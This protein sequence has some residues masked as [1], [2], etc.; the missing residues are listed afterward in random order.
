MSSNVKISKAASAKGAKNGESKRS[1]VAAA[2]SRKIVSSKPI[3]SGSPY[4]GDGMVRIRH[5]E[6]IGEIPGSVAFANVQYNVNPGL[7]ATFPW[8]SVVA[9][10]FESY[11][12]RRLSF[13]FET[14]KSTSTSGSI[15]QAIDFDAADAAPTSKIQ[16]MSY[17]HAVR[18]AV[19]DE[20]RFSS[21]GPDLKKFGVQRYI[22]SGALASNLDIKTYDVGV[23]NVATQGCADTTNIGELYVEYDVELHTP[24]LGSVTSEGQKLVGA[25]SV[26]K[27]A[28]LGTAPTSTGSSYF[29]GSSNTLTCLIPGEYMIVMYMT[30]TGVSTTIPV[31]GSATGANV[32]FG[33]VSTTNLLLQ[34][35]V[36][37]LV[38]G[39]TFILDFT[40]GTTYTA[41]SVWITPFVYSLF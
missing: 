27:T 34:Y 6:Y 24:Q 40:G 38:A 23:H 5:R 10:N 9:A 2:Y 21:D 32:N 12:F 36:Q 13:S 25:G 39:Q 35:K 1:S 31:S 14:E 26:S 4:Q 17:S 41:S 33:A 28:Y 16:L 11:L 22:R 20:C 19:W 29:S 8:L 15:M 7:S 30:G 3:M 37:A 18:S